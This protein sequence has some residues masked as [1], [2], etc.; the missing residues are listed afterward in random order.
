MNNFANKTGSF[1]YNQQNFTTLHRPQL[2]PGADLENSMRNRDM[3]K[4][5]NGG[6]MTISG[7]IN[8]SP[9]KTPKDARSIRNELE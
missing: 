3:F 2:Y 5:M 1:N 9:F 4:T 8:N 7:S 6:A